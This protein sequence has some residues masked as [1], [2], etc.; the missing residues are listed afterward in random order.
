MWNASGTFATR[1]S[2]GALTAHREIVLPD[3]DGTMVVATN[4]AFSVSGISTTVLSA[5]IAT[6]T[7]L[8]AGT[9]TVGNLLYSGQAQSAPYNVGG[10]LVSNRTAGARFANT[11]KMFTIFG[12]SAGGVTIHQSFNLSS[13]TR[14]ASGTYQVNA[15]DI[16][17]MSSGEYVVFAWNGS[18]QF[19][20]YATNPSATGFTVINSGAGGTAVDISFMN[21]GVLGI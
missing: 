4:G 11:F 20:G 19:A 2:A 5:S 3:A 13:V 8:T 10:S 15:A 21:V 14:T 16:T 12:G 7:T 9:I 17:G 6:I 18:L 1:F